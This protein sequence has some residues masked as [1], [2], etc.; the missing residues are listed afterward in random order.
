MYAICAVLVASTPFLQALSSLWAEF[1]LQCTLLEIF[2]IHKFPQMMQMII[3]GVVRLV[4]T[5]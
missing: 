5:S 2:V 4:I 3:N 1:S